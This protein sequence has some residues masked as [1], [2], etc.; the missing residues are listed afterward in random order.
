MTCDVSPV[1]MLTLKVI[2][3]NTNAGNVGPILGEFS[4]QWHCGPSAPQQAQFF[5]INHSLASP[6][7]IRAAMVLR[8]KEGAK[9]IK[10]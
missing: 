10:K 5:S 1:A 7:T 6:S 4:Y 9:L 2:V 8:L 3:F